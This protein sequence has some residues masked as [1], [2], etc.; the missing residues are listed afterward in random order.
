MATGLRMPATSRRLAAARVLPVLTQTPEPTAGRMKHPGGWALQ[1]H[2][3]NLGLSAFLARQKR[4]ATPPALLARLKRL[5]APLQ[6]GG[7]IPSWKPCGRWSE[8]ITSTH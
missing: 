5:A 7:S 2:D 3:G 6:L 4:L 1:S 8:R